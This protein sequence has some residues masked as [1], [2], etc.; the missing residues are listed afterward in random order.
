LPLKP[1]TVRCFILWLGITKSKFYYCRKRYGKVNEYNIWIPCDWWLA[2]GEKPA[3]RDFHALHPLQ[4]DR[5]LTFRMFDA[6]VVACSPASVS[7]LLRTAGLLD[8][9]AT[10]SSLTGTAFVQPRTLEHASRC[11]GATDR[12][13][14]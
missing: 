14:L 7:R 11:Q 13:F 3:I 12:V 9:R 1:I 4:G 5:C 10:K 8:Q 6:A 2:D